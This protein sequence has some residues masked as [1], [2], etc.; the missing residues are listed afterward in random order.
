MRIGARH[1]PG[2]PNS[3][4]FF[5]GAFFAHHRPRAGPAA[6]TLSQNSIRHAQILQLD[7]ADA[8]GMD[9]D[10]RAVM[11]SKMCKF[12]AAADGPMP[13]AK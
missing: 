5:I 12:Q 13:A 11:V 4:G 8:A 2:G 10:A 9:D 7:N 3:A 6:G 1:V